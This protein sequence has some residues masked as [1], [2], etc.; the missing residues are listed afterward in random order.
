MLFF[1]LIGARLDYQLLLIMGAIGFTYFLFRTFGKYV[2]AFVGAYIANAPS[3]VRKN[4]GLCLFSQAGVA[5]GLAIS[6]DIEFSQYGVDAQHLAKLVITVI[7]ASTFI[8]QII[9]PIMTKYALTKAG[10]TNV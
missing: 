7:T 9:G 6:L 1:V 5:I 4:I 8:F 10:E 3:K 2:G